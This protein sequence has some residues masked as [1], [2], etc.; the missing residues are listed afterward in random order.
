MARAF[1]RASSQYLETGSAVV[2]A[3]PFTVAC[4]FNSDDID[5]EQN[6][7]WIGDKDVTGHWWRL[8]LRGATVGDP[9]RFDIQS[10]G[11]IEVAATTTGYSANT[12]HHACGV[13]ASTSSRA[14][15]IDG[16]SKGTNTNPA[17]SPTAPDRTS[18]GRWATSS[19]G[20]YMSGM[21]AEVGVWNVALSDG[22]VA[23]LAKGI[24]PRLMRPASLVAYWPIIGRADPE[25]DLWGDTSTSLT[26]TGATAANTHPR[27]AYGM[28]PLTSA[29]GAAAT[30]PAADYTWLRVSR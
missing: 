1:V 6:L 13:T 29:R 2:A 25:P 3:P 27:I 21:I 8:V 12:W 14:V 22:D 11:A 4:W 18:V 5:T 24:S 16:G 28:G 19:P 30:P 15:Y 26:V 10:G 17:A 23:I 9:V 20:N 7:F